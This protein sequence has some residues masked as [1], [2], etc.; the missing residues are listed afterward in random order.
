[1]EGKEK[2][3]NNRQI[4]E[5]ILIFATFPCTLSP[6]H[7]CLSVGLKAE[8]RRLYFLIPLQCIKKACSFLMVQDR[9]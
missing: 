5:T 9:C 6:T 8:H 3:L 2:D 7:T 4:H 1:M